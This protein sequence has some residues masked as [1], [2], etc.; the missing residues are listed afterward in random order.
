MKKTLYLEGAGMLGTQRNDVEN[1][2]IRT[3]FVNDEGLKIYLEMGDGYKQEILTHNPKTGKEY[4]KAKVIST[5]N[6]LWVDHCYY[7]TD[8]PEIDD[9]NYSR[10][11][12]IERQPCTVEY[13]KENILN[14]VNSKLNCSFTDVV[15]LE[16][17][18]RVHAKGHDNYNFMEDIKV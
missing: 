5:P 12:E 1:C 15:I 13:T 4:K 18:Y 8:N 11:K 16:K 7:I 9:C 10:I 14:L 3:A 17:G 2:R 6:M